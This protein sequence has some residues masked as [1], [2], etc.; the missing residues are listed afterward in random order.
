MPALSIQTCARRCSSEQAHAVLWPGLFPAA[1]GV[2]NSGV[3]C[4]GS[5]PAGAFL[6]CRSL[7][8]VCWTPGRGSVFLGAAGAEQPAPHHAPPLLSNQIGSVA[9][10]TP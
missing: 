8:F 4:L 6:A 2:D 5:A 9:K 10:P 7:L 3:G 1:S